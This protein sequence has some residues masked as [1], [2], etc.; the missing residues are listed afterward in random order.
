MRNPSRAVQKARFRDSSCF[1]SFQ[2]MLWSEQQDIVAASKMSRFPPASSHS[3]E[4]QIL[5]NGKWNGYS[6]KWV[7][8]PETEN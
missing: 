5:G 6:L 3:K 7:W 4:L 1:E 8:N 2:E